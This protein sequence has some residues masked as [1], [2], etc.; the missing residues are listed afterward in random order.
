M[1]TRIN[2]EVESLIN[3]AFYEKFRGIA[4]PLLDITDI[5]DEAAKS[6]DGTALSIDKFMAA[7][8]ETYKNKN[9]RKS[10]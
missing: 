4:I 1:K 9:Q 5:C 6:Y 10:L 3:K 8:A 7:K 2:P